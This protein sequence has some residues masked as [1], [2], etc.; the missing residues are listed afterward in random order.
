MQILYTINR[1]QL[2]LC[3]QVTPKYLLFEEV[4]KA[5]ICIR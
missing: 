5:M 4:A 1:S 3:L 2:A